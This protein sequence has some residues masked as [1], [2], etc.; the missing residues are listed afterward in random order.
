MD[1]VEKNRLVSALLLF[2]LL[3]V[4]LSF[5][6][7]SGCSSDWQ[8]E[9]TSNLAPIVGFI[10]SPPESTN[11]SRN[12]VI[13]WWGSDPDGIIAFF[14]YHVATFDEL[15]PTS[16][17]VYIQTIDDTSW[18]VLEVDVA[19]S[20]PGTQDIIKLSADLDDPVNRFVQQ[21]VFLQAFDEE[22]MGSVIVW[23]IFGRND[24]P[25]QTILF[26]PS[27]ADL[28]FVDAAQAGGVITVVKI[29]LKG[30]DLRDFP[31]DRPPF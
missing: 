1:N 28:P 25:P 17:D 3:T 12:S 15:G 8:G 26:N 13:Y 10:N 9:A 30:E 16:P 4:P 21:Y 22:G 7:V 18:T 11:F 29:R 31:H 23:R 24:N 2:L 20:Q 27:S 14:R 6:F 19:N 5:L